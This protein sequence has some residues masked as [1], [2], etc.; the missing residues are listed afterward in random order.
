MRIGRVNGLVCFLCF[1]K[2]EMS[3]YKI[4]ALTELEK[5]LSRYPRSGFE[6]VSNY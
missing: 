4:S 1:I 6:T 5:E 2:A 3:I